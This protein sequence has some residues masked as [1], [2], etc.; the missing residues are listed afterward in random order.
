M[1]SPPLRRPSA[2]RGRRVPAGGTVVGGEKLRH[3]AVQVRT[4]STPRTSGVTTARVTPNSRAICFGVFPAARSACARS[5]NSFDSTEPSSCR[6]TERQDHPT[7]GRRHVQPGGSRHRSG[8]ADNHRPRR[9]S[10]RWARV[11][12]RSAGLASGSRRAATSAVTSSARCGSTGRS[13]RGVSVGTETADQVRPAGAVP[14]QPATKSTRPKS[15]AAAR[16]P[17]ATPGIWKSCSA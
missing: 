2:G 17:I 6:C 1:R 15:T 10:P 4:I 5:F 16:P 13:G 12:R 3:G 9:R 14:V 7:R 11:A 8:I